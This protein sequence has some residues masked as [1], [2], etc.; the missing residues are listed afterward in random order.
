MKP[1]VKIFL[2]LVTTL[3]AVLAVVAISQVKGLSPE[4]TLLW[5]VLCV[6]SEHFWVKTPSGDSVQSLAATAK[7]ATVLILDPWTA[8]LV[9][10]TSTVIGNF[11]FRRSMWYRALY[12][13]S[14]LMLAAG[15]AGLA[16]VRASLRRSRLG[17]SS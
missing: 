14:Q 16:L 12:N 2:T 6:V 13:G 5:V 8:V 1:K 11:L 4:H 15:I 9:V 3:A 10:F 7:L 17:S